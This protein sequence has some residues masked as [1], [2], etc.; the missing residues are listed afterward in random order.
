MG[1]R[2]GVGSRRGLSLIPARAA[3]PARRIFPAAPDH[4]PAQ[5]GGEPGGA[6][7]PCASSRSRKTEILGVE[8]DRYSA[9]G[10]MVRSLDARRA[11]LPMTV[12]SAMSVGAKRGATAPRAILDA[13]R[14]G[15]LR[16][17]ERPGRAAECDCQRSR[18]YD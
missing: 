6:R 18:Y 4:P 1:P 3:C 16:A 13:V 15:K 9:A 7:R 11:A 2:A 8:D 17:S 14:D 10:T 12:A 5:P